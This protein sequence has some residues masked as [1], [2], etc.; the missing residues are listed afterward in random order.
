[1]G[2]LAM[3]FYRFVAPVSLA[4]VF[5]ML[6]VLSIA[7]IRDPS[8]PNSAHAVQL[9]VG[10]AIGLGIAVGLFVLANFTR[11]RVQRQ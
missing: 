5:A 9:L 11:F 8:L 4:I 3:I 2:V 6:L 7:D 10:S 1:M